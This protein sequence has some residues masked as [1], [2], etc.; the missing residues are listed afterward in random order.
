MVLFVLKFMSLYG[1][2]MMHSELKFVPYLGRPSCKL[3]EPL[4]KI[5]LDH[6]F[7]RMRGVGNVNTD[8]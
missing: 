8:F 4:L 2:K 3:D 6:I 1:A 7:I 5:Y